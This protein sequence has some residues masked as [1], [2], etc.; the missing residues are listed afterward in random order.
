MGGKPGADIRVLEA[1]D[2]TRCS[3]RIVIA[4][5]D[6]G[7]DPHHPDLSAKLAPGATFARGTTSTSDGE[8]HGT[9]VAGIAAAAT[10]NSLGIAGVCPLGRI[11]PIKV[12]DSVGA[13]TFAAEARG[14]RWAV[15]HGARV[16]NVSLANPQNSSRVRAAVAYAYDHG[17][18]V[19]AGT[20]NAGVGT[21][22]YPV[23]Y[24]HVLAVG[25][26][27]NRDRRWPRSNYGPKDLVLAP[28]VGI[29][30]TSSHGNLNSYG[31]WTGTSM[32]APQVAG[33]AALLLSIRPDLTADQIISAIE[34]GADPV[35]GQTGYKREDGWGRIDCY[36]S[37]RIVQT[38]TV[39]KSAVD[40]SN[41]KR[42]GGLAT[43]W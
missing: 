17:V 40:S 13:A 42:W 28:S 14:I 43:T 19:V 24:P 16:I 22:M 36:R 4:I 38:V 1:W 29:F 7:V 27:D 31:E 26:S 30:T 2:I 12:V 15:D 5:V 32:A 41:I 35:E 20:G 18:V 33:L 39:R 9:A 10:N 25:G 34:R 37:V 21:P 3:P 23:A 11:M 6:T 8:G